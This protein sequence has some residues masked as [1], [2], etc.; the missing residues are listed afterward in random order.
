M[1][2]MAHRDVPIDDLSFENS[3]PTQ[4]RHLGEVPHSSVLT[5]FY[6][7]VVAATVVSLN[8]YSRYHHYPLQEST[9][10]FVACI[11]NIVPVNLTKFD[12][13]ATDSD[14]H[15]QTAFCSDLRSW[16]YQVLCQNKFSP[17]TRHSCFSASSIQPRHFRNV[18]PSFNKG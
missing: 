16:Y 15:I 1:N 9:S 10:V 14:Q 2:V 13:G 3:L 7:L 5:S 6:K 12:L 17:S 8:Q 11:S 18:W 4:H